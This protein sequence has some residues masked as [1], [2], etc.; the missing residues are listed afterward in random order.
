MSGPHVDEFLPEHVLG[1]LGQAERALVD[2]HLVQCARCSVERART[3]DTLA[4]LGRA[5]VAAP[6]SAATRERLLKRVRGVGRFAPFA[7]RLAGLFDLA[8]EKAEALLDTL[9]EPAHWGPGP[10]GGSELYF[11]P[12]G[13]RLASAEAGFV[14][15]L[16]GTLFPKH[17]HLGE[18]TTRMM[19]GGVREDE[20]GE[21]WRPGDQVVRAGKTQHSFTVLDEGCLFAVVVFDGVDFTPGGIAVKHVPRA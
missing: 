8:V 5:L 7:R 20:S 16:P 17:E 12:R 6:P 3:A 4:D 19:A 21:I 15:L 13:P 11:V 14:R 10:A 2:S 9:E 18:E 1:T